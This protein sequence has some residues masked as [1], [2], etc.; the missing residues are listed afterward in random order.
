MFRSSAVNLNLRSGRFHVEVSLFSSPISQRCDPE[1]DTYK[2]F[3]LWEV[4][5]N[6]CFV[7]Y[8]P[9]LPGPD[10]E[11]SIACWLIPE[12]IVQDGEHY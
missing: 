11:L 5:T 8:R 10:T 9:C 7:L 2:G 4:F 6:W 1:F 3:P 12:P